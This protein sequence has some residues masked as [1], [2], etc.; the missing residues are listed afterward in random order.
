MT[1]STTTQAE[2]RWQ[3]RPD[4]GATP[5]GEWPPLVARLLALRGIS[6]A[7]EAAAYF[8]LEGA[9]HGRPQLPDL[10]AA[11]ARLS[12]ACGGGET[13]AVYGDFDVDG[14]T[15]A[16]LLTEG[17]TDL[18]AKPVPY[19]PHRISEGYGLNKDAIDSLQAL[20]ATLL[21][22]ADCGT[23]SIAEIAHARGL[24]MDVMILDHHTVPPQLPLESII[25][26]PKRDAR[27]MDEPAAC[28]IAYYVLRALYQSRGPAADE[29]RAKGGEV[30]DPNPVEATGRTIINGRDPDGWRI[31]FVDA[32]RAAPTE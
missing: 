30:S 1:T 10:D 27:I 9:G 8:D 6:T 3:G 5:K 2:T 4:P 14:V 16:A 11:V 24:G 28:G 32:K 20:G 15:A 25:V 13:V 17:L 19:I 29:R 26:N 18:G 31:Q 7:A 21:V 23:S 12:Q 22:T